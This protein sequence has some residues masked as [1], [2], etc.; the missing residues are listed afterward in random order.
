M[1]LV[2][3]LP[4]FS[5]APAVGQGSAGL[6]PGFT[7]DPK[8]VRLETG[9]LRHL[10]NALHMMAEKGSGD[11]LAIIERAYLANASP[12]L[13][14]WAQRYD[15]TSTSMTSAIRRHPSAYS[16]ALAG[17]VLDQEQSLRS[18]FAKL[19]DL[20]PR[21][22]FPPVWFFAGDYRAG[23]LA[24]PEGVLIAV[25]RFSGEPQDVVP[26]VM[27]EVAHVQSAM[28]QGID[29]YQRIFGPEQTLLAL[30]LREGSAELIAE[31]AASRHI[32]PKAERY[33][34]E[35]ERDL[36]LQF[37]EEM[38]RS[39]VGDWMFVEPGN[40]EWPPDLGYWIGYRILRSYY[41]HAE[42]KQKAIDDILNLTDFSAFL[43]ASRYAEQFD[44]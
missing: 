33:G 25:E 38:H 5:S 18:A 39:E 16:D 40:S 3:L 20:F 28:L 23:G 36:W 13:R 2:L 44:P 14:A 15:V 10:Q 19:Q 26:L 11:T 4:A 29:V 6:P 35:H 34:L 42:D 30:A 43:T 12:G 8:Q 24:R 37:R 27:H 9:D 21:A 31:L 1:L 22:V 7:M 41:D 32:N 17:S